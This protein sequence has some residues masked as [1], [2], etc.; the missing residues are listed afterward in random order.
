MYASGK[1]S[2]RELKHTHKRTIV[3][4]ILYCRTSMHK[5][6]EKDKEE[7]VGSKDNDADEARDEQRETPESKP[8]PRHTHRYDY[9]RE[10]KRERES[11]S[12]RRRWDTN[13][14]IRS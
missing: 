5:W 3:T 12:E 6:M 14:R 8:E 1:H 10:R 9:E 2:R 7:P 13:A 11:K 4:T